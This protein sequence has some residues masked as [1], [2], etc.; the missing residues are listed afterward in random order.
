MNGKSLRKIVQWVLLLCYMLKMNAYSAY[1]LK[2]HSNH[3]K[4]IIP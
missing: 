2:D 4:Q 3:E 1:I